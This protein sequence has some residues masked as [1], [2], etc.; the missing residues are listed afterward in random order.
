[1]G[2]DGLGLDGRPLNEEELFRYTSGRSVHADVDA[3]YVPLRRRANDY[4]IDREAQKTQSFTGITG[5]S[6]QDACVQDSQGRIADRTRETLTP[7]DE[8]VV[9]FRK[10]IMGLARDLANGKQPDAAGKPCAYTT[11]SGG[12]IAAE[13]IGLADVMQARFGDPRGVIAKAP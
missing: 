2:W 10:L 9:R 6:E 5:L 13:G 8:G 1:M 4:L 11:R 12:A 3:D 7:S